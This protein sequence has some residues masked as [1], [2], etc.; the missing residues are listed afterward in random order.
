MN[1]KKTLVSLFL[2][3][4]GTYGMAQV[5]VDVNLNIKHSVDGIS[6]FGRER[7]MTIH[8]S[9]LETDWIGEEDKL[10]YLIN[11]LHVFFGRDNG[12]ATWKFKATTQDPA[13]PNMPNV[14]QMKGLGTWLKGEYESNTK[15]HQYYKNG[16]MIMGTNP[17]PT[18]PT[19]SWN[20]DGNTTEGWAPQNV[21]TSA[22]WMEVY[23]DN[24]FSKGDGAPG[25]PMPKYW[26][27]INEPDMIMM[28]GSM[29]CTSQEKLWEY[30]NLVATKVKARLGA[31][32]PKIGGMTW[33]LH[34]LYNQDGVSRYGQDHYD[35]WLSAES[36]PV[37]HAMMDSEV[38]KYRANDWYQ[39]D[40]MWQGFIDACGAN[41]DFHSVHIYDW[42]SWSADNI[43]I[44]A[45]GH[46]EA[47]LD[48]LEWYDNFKFG[49]KKDV[50]LSEY[51]AVSNYI[52]KPTLDTKRRDWENLKPFNSM[53]MQFLERPSQI[54]LSMPFTPIKAEWGDYKNAAGVV[55]NRYPY[56]MMN[57]DASGKWQ[58][59]EFV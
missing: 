48:L 35:Q 46:T 39:W 18:Y 53:L 55:T 13:R 12:S 14:E 30:H 52:D 32:A 40:V 15:V 34:D 38:A 23:L 24:F 51:G 41:M 27:V 4:L 50:L 47:M 36:K 9:P 11:D 44:R 3:G 6:D 33:G 21:E 17:H 29:T 25:E 59:T 31:K 43:N 56:T 5:N 7:H 58:W 8:S 42:P 20:G 2:L 45:G 49:K 1:I 28:T 22:E 10:D 16:G 19:L 57:K 26:E 54:I 37:Y